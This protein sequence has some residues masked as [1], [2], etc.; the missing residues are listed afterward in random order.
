[1]MSDEIP[2]ID[3]SQWVGELEQVLRSAENP[4]RCEEALAILQRWQF[5]EMLDDASR[6]KAKALFGSSLDSRSGCTPEA[7]NLRANRNPSRRFRRRTRLR[8]VADDRLWHGDILDRQHLPDPG[9]VRKR[10]PVR[11]S[12]RLTCGRGLSNL[13]GMLAG[14]LVGVACT[15]QSGIRKGRR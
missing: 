10:L 8:H 14:R 9:H 4:V 15:R 6:E 1:M 12:N 11:A 3:V 13:C 5:D 7:V 2:K